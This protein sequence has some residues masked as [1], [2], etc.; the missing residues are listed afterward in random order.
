M[1]ISLLLLSLFVVVAAVVVVRIVAVVC[2]LVL[3]VAEENDG[4]A[5]IIVPAGVFAGVAAV[6]HVVLQLQSPAVSPTLC[7]HACCHQ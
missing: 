6:A 3:F 7:E 5:G 4:V 2:C 1:V